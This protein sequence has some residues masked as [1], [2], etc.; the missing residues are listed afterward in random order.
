MN[1]VERDLT[2]RLDALKAT[3][4]QYGLQSYEC[5]T[6]MEIWQDQHDWNVMY[7]KYGDYFGIG[8]LTALLIVFFYYLWLS[9]LNL[10]NK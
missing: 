3:C 2:Y 4:N 5:K 1:Q 9:S 6:S 8:S 7:E 10:S